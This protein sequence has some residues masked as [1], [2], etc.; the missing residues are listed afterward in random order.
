MRYRRDETFR[1]T[2]N[3]PK[4]GLFQIVKVNGKDVESKQGK[5]LVHNISPR[6]MQVSTSFDLMFK[7]GK[8]II[9]QS[10]FEL[11]TEHT[12]HGRIAWQ[13]RKDSYFYGIDLIIDDQQSDYIIDDLKQFIHNEKSNL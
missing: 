8:D 12:V 7:E 3:Q 4:H 10:T 13:K 6:G 5:F 11:V 2:F 1:Y 9:I